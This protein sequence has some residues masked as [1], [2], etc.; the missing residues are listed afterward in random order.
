[1]P[2]RG[3]EFWEPKA[4]GEQP[5]KIASL[6]GLRIVRA[7]LSPS[8]R[9]LFF[10]LEGNATLMVEPVEAIGDVRA[11]KLETGSATPNMDWD[12]LNNLMI[13]SDPHL[14]ELRGRR[15]EGIDADVLM[16]TGGVGAQITPE[17]VQ[18]VRRKA[19]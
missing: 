6:I 4:R 17:R 2:E 13:A 10:L 18:W 7:W 16:F 19:K 14:R 9:I 15:F 11:V 1:M 12:E 8:G 3:F 5:P